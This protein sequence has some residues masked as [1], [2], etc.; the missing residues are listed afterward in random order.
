MRFREEYLEYQKKLKTISGNTNI[1]NNGL[2]QGNQGFLP[3]IKNTSMRNSGPDDDYWYE[4][5]KQ[6]K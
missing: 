1:I 3:Q 4:H 6:K 2:S 5:N